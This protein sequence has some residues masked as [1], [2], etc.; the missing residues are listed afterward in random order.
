MLP[1]WFVA[2]IAFASPAP[3]TELPVQIAMRGNRFHLTS[4]AKRDQV[5]IQ[6]AILDAPEPKKWPEKR[7]MFRKDDAYAVW[8]ARGL[9]TRNGAWVHSSQLTEIPVSP[10]IFTKDEIV[11]TNL[12]VQ[13]G[14]RKRAASHLLGALRD[15]TKVYLLL[16]WDE[17]DG[18]PWLEAVSVVDLADERPKSRLVGRFPGFSL[19]LRP[20]ENRFFLREGKI[21]VWMQAEEYWGLG[22]LETE[23]EAFDSVRVG[24][25]LESI[26]L[27]NDKLGWFVE[28]TEHPSQVLGRFHTSLLH[29]RDLVETRGTVRLMDPRTPWIVVIHDDPGVF[30]QN[31]ETGARMRLPADPG[32]RWTAFGVLVWSPRAKPVSATLYEPGRWSRLGVLKAG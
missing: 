7:L 17:T 5:P 12:L 28:R 9:T 21:S 15:G 13:G 24:S 16:R 32:F 25:Q 30:L 1:T 31:L 23:T 18:N 2:W 8:D 26:G 10:K 19:D 27:A 3:Q 14:Q 11:Q 20:G 29:R 22:T 6:S 4:G